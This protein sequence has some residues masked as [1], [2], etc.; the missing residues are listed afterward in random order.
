MD[1]EERLPYNISLAGETSITT[2]GVGEKI[3]RYMSEHSCS[4]SDWS[5]SYHIIQKPDLNIDKGFAKMLFT[6][7]E[8]RLISEYNPMFNRTN[9]KI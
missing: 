8:A 5:Y 6:N 1:D 3:N 9:H 4:L 2:S 7:F